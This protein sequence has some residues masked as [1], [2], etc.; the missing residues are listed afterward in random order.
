MGG[1]R[2]QIEERILSLDGTDDHATDSE[3]AERFGVT[4]RWIGQ[5]RH[6]LFEAG[7]IE[8]TS[9]FA[10][11]SAKWQAGRD[12]LKENPKASTSQVASA[13]GVSHPT[14]RKIRRDWEQ[15]KEVDWEPWMEGE[16]L[17]PYIGSKEK[18]AGWILWDVPAF[19]HLENPKR[20][21]RL[22]DHDTFVEVFGGSATLLYNKPPSGTEVYNDLDDDFAHF[23]RTLRDHG[24]EIRYW[25]EG[26]PYER[27][28]YD[29]WEDKWYDDT[30]W[31]NSEDRPEDDVKRAAI[32][33]YL[34][35]P[36]F[37]PK[38]EGAGFRKPRGNRPNPGEYY[39]KR[40]RLEMFQRRFRRDPEYFESRFDYPFSPNTDGEIKI[41]NSDYRDVLDEYDSEKTLFYLDPPYVDK[42]GYYD[43]GK[44]FDHDEL[45]KRVTA[46]DGEFIL[47]YGEVLPDGLG[48]YRQEI[49]EHPTSNKG[50]TERLF[51]SFPEEQ[52]GGFEIPTTAGPADEW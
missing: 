50:R 52:E 18:I 37:I 25:L 24:E 15:R 22:P 49:L 21:T 26:K 11:Q 41:E 1:T 6:Q 9:D 40:D 13:V 51:F 12:F 34:R 5:I 36:E 38:N 30:G 17:F 10:P 27:E 31:Y 14:A 47:S 7:E 43:E 16:S 42:E 29:E 48:N 19:N 35:F 39:E 23:F 28:L 3:L 46:L 20:Y 2:E 4:G 8:A 32:F 33:F 44:G 45:I